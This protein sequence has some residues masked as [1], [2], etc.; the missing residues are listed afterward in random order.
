MK[1]I[2]KFFALALSVMSLSVSVASCGRVDGWFDWMDSGE[3]S[4]HTQISSSKKDDDTSSEIEAE[5]TYL[6]R[7]EWGTDK[8]FIVSPSIA[9]VYV[10]DSFTVTATLVETGEALSFKL[11]EIAGAGY[12]SIEGT[13]VTTLK[14]GKTTIVVRE[15]SLEE[16]PPIII[17]VEAIIKTE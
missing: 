17:E 15:Y 13:T 12:V 3:S 7:Q 14:P 10:G 4:R 5:E 9:R 1:K 16:L 6:L 11:Y 2:F 8:K